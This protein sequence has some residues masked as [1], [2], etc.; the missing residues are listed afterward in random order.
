MYRRTAS[1]DS[2]SSVTST[3]FWGDVEEEVEGRESRDSMSLN[4]PD[5]NERIDLWTRN[6]TL[7]LERIVKSESGN[8]KWGEMVGS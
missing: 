3:I 8:V 7:S 5:A 2:P 6:S 4:T 1:M